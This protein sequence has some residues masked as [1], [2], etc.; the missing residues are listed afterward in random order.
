MDQVKADSLGASSAPR[1]N[2]GFA[3]GEALLLTMFLT[4]FFDCIP[5]KRNYFA[6]L[7]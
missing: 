5:M 2:P 6:L 3:D 1:G 7:V 4:M